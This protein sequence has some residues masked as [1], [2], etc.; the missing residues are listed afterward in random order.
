VPATIAVEDDG[1]E[2][3]FGAEARAWRPH[4]LGSPIKAQRPAVVTADRH[5]PQRT[6]AEA[7]SWPIAIIAK[8]YMPR[9]FPPPLSVEETDGVICDSDLSR[10][11]HEGH[12]DR[13][14][15]SPWR[16]KA[17]RGEH[18][19]AAGRQRRHNPWRRDL[20]G[21]TVL[22]TLLVDRILVDKHSHSAGDT[23]IG[24]VPIIAI[25]IPASLAC[26]STLAAPP[27]FKLGH[28]ARNN[29]LRL[30]ELRGRVQ[31]CSR[32]GGTATRPPDWMSPVWRAA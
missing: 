15:Q 10:S 16:G 19:Q 13:N 12:G 5:L 9:R 24:A 27:K 14:A 6:D 18:R 31:A 4:V 7:R 29:A 21:M 30:P 28:H 32:R 17:D 26:R 11:H 20:E 3:T 25:P 1:R 8:N 2:V 23:L 22:D